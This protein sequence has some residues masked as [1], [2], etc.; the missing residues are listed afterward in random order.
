M[1][2]THL[3][4]DLAIE[5]CDTTENQSGAQ[6]VMDKGSTLASLTR[7]CTLCNRAEFRPG[8]VCGHKIELQKIGILI[9]H[10]QVSSTTCFLLDVICR[11]MFQSFAENA[12]VMPLRS[13]C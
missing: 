3:R 9:D 4:Y 6:Q 8:Q 2:P 10:F 1:F 12:L 7:I 5:E 11:T 13:L